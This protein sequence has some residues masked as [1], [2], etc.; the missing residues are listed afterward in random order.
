MNLANSASDPE[1][2]TRSDPPAGFPPARQRPP[3]ALVGSGRPGEGPAAIGLTVE[4][5]D[6]DRPDV[7]FAANL[8]ALLDFVEQAR[9]EVTFFVDH[10]WVVANPS[11]AR[12]IASIASGIGLSLRSVFP[13]AEPAN[14][15]AEL[16]HRLA[17]VQ[18]VLAGASVN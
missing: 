18:A 11:L 10:R 14:I 9:L 16:G 6:P 8:E 4:V 17:Q 15:E 1:S 7:D 12:R 5:E 2:D 3:V 13:I